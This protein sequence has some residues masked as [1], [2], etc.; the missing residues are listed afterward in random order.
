[1]PTST[2]DRAG[3]T[4]RPAIKSDIEAVWRLWVGLQSLHAE[5]DP[6]NYVPA[7]GLPRFKKYF[8]KVLR[9]DGREVIVAERTGDVV[10]YIVL[11]EVQ[12]GSDFVMSAQEWLE[13]EHLVVAES[14]RRT[15]VAGALLDQAK[16]VAQRKGLSQIKVG[17]RAFNASAVS[18]YMRLGFEHDFH[19]M[20]LPLDHGRED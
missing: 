17:V 14:A 15:G 10:G 13:L 6:V 16:H 5:A 8:E 2:S 9:D 20:S 18:A 3:L 11:R 1:M 7:A 19:H 4:V 12:R